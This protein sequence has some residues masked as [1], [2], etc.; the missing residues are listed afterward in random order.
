MRRKVKELLAELLVLIVMV[1]LLCS[2]VLSFLYVETH[3]FKC[4]VV[5]ILATIALCSF[6]WKGELV[7]A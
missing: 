4:V 3:F 2:F 1:T 7:S 5:G 6:R